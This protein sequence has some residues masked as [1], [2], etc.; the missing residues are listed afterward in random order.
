LANLN[1][2]IYDLLQMTRLASVF[3]IEKD[4][5]SAIKSLNGDATIK[6]VA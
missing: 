5:A 4:E 1:K 2:R 6:N 3:D